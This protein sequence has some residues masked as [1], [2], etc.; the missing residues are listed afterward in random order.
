M[1]KIDKNIV[2]IGMPG[3][4]KSTIGK[5]VAK[6]LGLNFCDIDEYLVKKQGIS[7]PEIFK[8]GEEHFRDIETQCVKDV[9]KYAN[10]VISTGGGVVKRKE[11]IFALKEKGIVIFINRPIENIVSDVDTESRPLLKDDI[12]RLYKLYEERYKLYKEYCDHEVINNGQF[13]DA[14]EKILDIAKIL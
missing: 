4:G 11:N 3:C 13:I 14:V 6:K 5:R 12:S 10:T 7:I 8:Q 1:M 9:S 2:L